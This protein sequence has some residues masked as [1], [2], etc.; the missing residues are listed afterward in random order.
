MPPIG[1]QLSTPSCRGLSGAKRPEGKHGAGVRHGTTFDRR[2]NER[3]A[4]VYHCG[5]PLGTAPCQRR[6]RLCGR[7]H[8]SD[9]HRLGVAE[10]RRRPDSAETISDMG[11]A[12][13]RENAPGVSR[14]GGTGGSGNVAVA[15][16]EI[17]STPEGHRPAGRWRRATHRGQT[18]MA[19]ARA[20]FCLTDRPGFNPRGIPAGHD[21][22]SSG[23]THRITWLDQWGYSFVSPPCHPGAARFFG[24]R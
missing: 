5:F 24:L 6:R 17:G 19:V 3:S 11:P 21:S 12:P 18:A 4:S 22:S 2:R 9:S 20:R 7:E 15:V 16:S 14:G 13:H 23:S 8:S 1:V 10:T